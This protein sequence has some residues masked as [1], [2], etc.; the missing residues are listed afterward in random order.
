MSFTNSECECSVEFCLCQYKN[1]IRPLIATILNADRKEYAHESTVFGNQDPE[2]IHNLEIAHKIRQIQM[3]EGD[4]AQTCF[5]KFYGWQDLGIGHS[6]GLDCMKLD[7][8]VIIELKNKYNTCNSG[9]QLAILDKL[10]KYKIEH[11][12]TLCVWG[13]VNEKHG[14]KQLTQKIIHMGVEIY[15]IQGRDL[16]RLV[17]EVDGNDYSNNVIEFVKEV[18]YPH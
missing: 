7:G 15:K 10:A 3:K 12:E 5:G 14:C 8:S 13:I 2:Y 11:P 1:I 17:Y 6:S 4:I 9:S 18:M 16:F